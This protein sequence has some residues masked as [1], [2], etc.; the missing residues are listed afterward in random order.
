MK[1]LRKSRTNKKID[2][3]CGGIGAYFGVDHT[4]I[5]LGCVALSFMFGG[6]LFVY[7]L[8]AIIMPEGQ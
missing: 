1:E 3:V 4:I 5:R 8:A 7:V 6:G 2:G